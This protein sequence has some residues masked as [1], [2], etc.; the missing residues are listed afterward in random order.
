MRNLSLPLIAQL[1]VVFGTAG[2]FWPEKF[3]AIFDVLMFPWP[4][5]HR[6]VRINSAAAILM[7]VVLF[8]GLIVRNQ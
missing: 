2:L 7:A 1:C 8:A 4:A 6:T 3:V 5:N